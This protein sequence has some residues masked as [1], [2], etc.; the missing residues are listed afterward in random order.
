MRYEAY[1]WLLWILSQLSLDKNQ[2]FFE[3]ER[4]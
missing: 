4:L 2:R 1:L 3:E